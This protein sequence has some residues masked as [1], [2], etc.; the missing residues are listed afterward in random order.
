ML[1]IMME[2]DI[3][4]FLILKKIFFHQKYVFQDLL[5]DGERCP[6]GGADV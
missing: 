4:Q 2:E 3:E 1:H 5:L 6:N